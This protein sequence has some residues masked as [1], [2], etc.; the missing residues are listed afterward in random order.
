MT[1]ANTVPCHR[2]T[3]RGPKRYTAEEVVLLAILRL[4]ERT[5][6]ADQDHDAIAVE[7]WMI[8]PATFSM[9]GHNY[10]DNKRASVTL[11]QLRSFRRFKE[12]QV[13]LAYTR[14]YK[15]TD[16]GRV[17]VAKLETA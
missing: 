5:G 6:H 8:D 14:C 10:P 2:C 17:R 7:A 3:R 12:P 13:K 16:A 11:T 1:L 9:K 15:L 4:E